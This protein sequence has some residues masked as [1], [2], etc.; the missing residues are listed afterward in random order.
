MIPV[1]LQSGEDRR[2]LVSKAVESLGDPFFDRLKN[3]RSVFVKVD[4]SHHERQLASTHVDAVRG[5]LDVIFLHARPEVMVGDG[6]FTGTVAAFRNFGFDRLVEEYPHTSLVDLN[7]DEFV[8][9][10]VLR[11]DGSVIP[12]HRSRMASQADLR[13]SLAPMKIHREYGVAL[14]VLNWVLGTWI[15][16]PR[17]SPRGLVYARSPWLSDGMASAHRSFMELWRQCPCDVGIIDGIDAM[18]GD[19]PLDGTPLAFDAVLAGMDPVAVDAIGSAMMDIEPEQ[20]PYLA[21]CDQ[22]RLGTISLG[23]INIPPIEL[24]QRKYHFA[25]PIG[26]EENLASGFIV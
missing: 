1:V 25:R 5:L 24:L 8:E 7:A 22:E 19:G 9:G 6:G 15:V 17:V 11:A 12:I 23:H 14:T 20:I 3:A 26:F 21:F 18:E 4:L 13:I 10:S 16:P 2:R